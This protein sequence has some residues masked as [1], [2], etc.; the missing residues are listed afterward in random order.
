MNACATVIFTAM[1][2]ISSTALAGGQYETSANN[3][4]VRASMRA[5]LMDH[6]GNP[7]GMEFSRDGK[8]ILC[9][10]LPQ[11]PI[12]DYD[13]ILG[14]CAVFDLTGAVVSSATDASGH[15]APEHVMQFATTASR[16]HLAWFLADT[17][18]MYVCLWG[19][20]TDYSLG[21][22]FLKPEGYSLPGD[23]EL[24]G[25]SPTPQRR[26][27]VRLPEEIAQSGLAG[28]LN[29]GPKDR[30]LVA[31]TGVSAYVLLAEDGSVVDAFD[32]ALAGGKPPEL[33]AKSLRLFAG[34]LAFDP[35]R[36]LLACGAAEGKR[37]RVMS[38]DLP[39]R[40][41]FEAHV[42]ENP[43]RPRG[44]LWSVDS[45]SFAG[46]GRY[47][48]AGYKFGGRATTKSLNRVEIFDTGPWRIV[49]STDDAAVSSALP[50]KV[51]PDG[52]TLALIRGHWLEISPFGSSR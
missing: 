22:R 5:N 12:G 40:A 28:F 41:V 48:I 47:L 35:S 39:H 26:W 16:Q 10:R 38:V 18:N 3:P 2:A 4:G 45:L 42:G 21:F 46:G 52:K 27:R 14:K 15:V 20:S 7:A 49:W 30:L 8:Y 6:G 37:V 51:S 36:R 25:L 43:R 19:F 33:T 29:S 17:N 32:Y 44:G 13:K 23:G 50:P 1:L 9:W 11:P 34:A 24:W 31:F